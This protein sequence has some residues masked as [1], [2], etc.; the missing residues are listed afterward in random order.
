MT[1]SFINAAEAKRS[2]PMSGV[3]TA[4]S[5]L[6]GGGAPDTPW[7]RFDAAWYR[8][9]Y[10]ETAG[11][12]ADDALAFYLEKGSGLGHAPNMFFDEV[13]YRQTYPEVDMAVQ[14]GEYESGFDEYCRSGHATRS[15][16]WLFDNALYR[17]YYADLTD[18]VLAANGFVNRY[19]HYLRFGDRENRL[20]HLFFDP[21]MYRARYSA[22][23]AAIEQA[24]P[25]AHY[26]SRLPAAARDTSPG[27]RGA[28]EA[29][30]RTGWYFDPEWY[31]AKYPPIGDAIAEGTWAAAL[32][33][34]LC[35]GTPTDFDP[36]P[37]FSEAYYLARYEDVAQ[38]VIERRLR[39]GY[40]H[41]LRSGVFELRAPCETVDLRYYVAANDGV[42]Q[43]LAE[44]RARDALAHF[45][46]IGRP[47]GAA[48]RPPVDRPPTETEARHLFIAA[49]RAQL[50]VHGRRVLDFSLGRG[51][52][53]VSVCMVLHN[54]F[55][56]TMQALASLRA[57]FAGAIELIL[58]DSG[59]TDET[60]HITSYVA[61]AR[62][63]R[64]ENNIGFVR[65]CNAGFRIAQA[66]AVL[67]LNNDVT[68]GPGAIAA[69]LGRL[70]S[71]PRIGAV[72]GKVIR[73]HGVLQ[74]AGCIIWGDGF[75]AGYMRDESPL[76]P[77]ANFV[78][79][80]DFC[81]G[82]FLMLRAD[83]LRVMGGLDEAFAP[84]YYE[85]TDLCVRIT[86][87]GWRIVY[88]PAVTLNHLEYGSGGQRKAEEQI[89]RSRDI[90]VS[91]HREW[92]AAKPL[93]PTPPPGVTVGS[94][95]DPAAS[96][97]ARS[98]RV[99][100]PGFQR[101]L[102]IEDTLPLRGIGSGFVRSNDILRAMADLGAAVTVFPVNGC[103]F[104][105]AAVYAD[106]P[107][108]VEAL[109]DR[110]ETDLDAHLA[111]RAGFYDIVWIART[112]N[113]H[114]LHRTLARHCGQIPWV[115]DTE[116]IVSV[117][118]AARARLDGADFDL[119]A[120][121]ATEFSQAH[122]CRRIVAVNAQEAALLRAAGV[123]PVAILGHARS[124]APAGPG[125]S[126][127]AG[128]LFIG[129]IHEPDSPN[130]DSLIWLID[131]VLPLVEAVLGPEIRL[132]V[133]GYLGEGVRLERFAGRPSV[134]LLG[135]V[136]DTTPLYEKHRVFVAPTRFSAGIPYKVHES[137]SFGLPVVAT[138]LLAEQ[139]GWT[140]GA[141]LLA[142]AQNDAA[143]FAAA[144][145]SLYRS[146]PLWTRL[147]ATALR[148]I[149]SE[150]DPK[151][152]R[153]TVGGL[154]RMNG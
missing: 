47:R 1:A 76:A 91:K 144:I 22:Q 139:L 35:N 74:E 26:L 75:T 28:R 40:D 92:L 89:V 78:R 153:E 6:L 53:A 59:S 146:E 33:H 113:L 124:P 125:F 138:R 43:D 15:P 108:T 61:G 77:E 102:F 73:S 131:E 38:G 115:L 97:H 140:N 87:A 30:P 122:L 39:C 151:T 100:E 48:A 118:L 98:P 65:G 19:D 72:G 147:R 9:M 70:A 109:H 82:A 95:P 69:A 21:A 32:Q 71:D 13:W 149:E 52:P 25:F 83:V 31:R 135:P 14:I 2:V 68:L 88:D 17:E 60:R 86:R 145:I 99:T 80:V 150:N 46:S 56:L 117:R 27:S 107:E 41:F 128:L 64:F 136:A 137:A 7:A 85:E 143:G 132:T 84:A 134:T 54:Q 103:R 96:L 36:L 106:M 20:G 127:R 67:M 130:H 5:L 24:G 10:A 58:V 23:A 121:I 94:R 57:C 105:L 42:A 154:L 4:R 51:G 141:D 129:A 63:L 45:L 148:R 101:V 49:A 11:L 120:A 104:D 8:G 66:P 50:P 110:A 119:P 111:E 114:R 116:A 12:G 18:E 152:Y 112:H 37:E 126:A 79:D 34:Y 142:A 81:S 3:R 93:Q 90:F 123:G 29:E 55:A 44:R 62:L 133:V 16:H